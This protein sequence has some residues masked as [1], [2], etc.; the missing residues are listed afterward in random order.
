MRLPW[1]SLAALPALAIGAVARCAPS[2]LTAAF[3]L[4]VCAS[5]LCFA[6]ARWAIPRTRDAHVR[7]G[8]AGADLNKRCAA[9]RPDD[10]APRIPESMGLEPCAAF[11][12]AVLVLASR[13][14]F[15]AALFPA[16]LAVIVAMLLGFAD[17]VLGIPW[18]AKFLI[19]F[20]TSLPLVLNYTGSTTVCV[21]GFLAPL[22]AALGCECRD[23]GRLYLTY[24]VALNV[25]CTHCINIYAG[26]NGLE[27]GQAL[28]VASF[29][30]LHAL[31]YWTT[32]EGWAA[33]TLL[34]PFIGATL[35][36]LSFSWFPSRVFVGDV[37]T[38][39]AGAVVAAAGTVGHFAEM[40]LLFMVPQ[41]LNFVVSLPQLLGFVHCPRHRLPALNRATGKLEGQRA[42]LNLVNWW[43]VL[44]GPKTESRLCVELLALQ[45]ACCLAAYAIKYA[46][47]TAFVP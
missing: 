30:L 37:F 13:S 31:C 15:A 46:Y 24:V 21:H 3:G 22:R 29:L 4:T 8:L 42:N 41:V 40:T 19:P 9:E 16:V 36:L 33:A 17:D 5:L 6:V 47:N 43:L 26:I 45:V 14:P 18:R 27:A 38:L 25:F 35:A 1:H 10:R 2:A 23:V 28:V 20:L 11:V 34:M 39:T 32:A 12:V 7:A 44:F